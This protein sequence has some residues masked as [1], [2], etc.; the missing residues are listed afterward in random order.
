MSDVWDFD[1]C[2]GRVVAGFQN[3]HPHSPGEPAKVCTRGEKWKLM[4][5][6]VDSFLLRAGRQESPVFK[7][8]S[9]M[10]EKT[11]VNRVNKM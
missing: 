1:D 10:K 3:P 8:A 4:T 5:S 6:F 11:I 9:Y 2:I 7:G